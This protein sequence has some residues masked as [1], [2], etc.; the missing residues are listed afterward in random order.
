MNTYST[1]KQQNDNKEMDTLVNGQTNEESPTCTPW[2][3]KHWNAMCVTRGFMF[4]TLTTVPCIAT[5]LPGEGGREEREGGSEGA[6][7]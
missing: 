4:P 6:R 1:C 5:H 2:Q 3:R 7:E